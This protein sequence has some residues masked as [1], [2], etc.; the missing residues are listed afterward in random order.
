MRLLPPLLLVVMAAVSFPSLGLAQTKNP[1]AERLKGLTARANELIEAGR[2]ADALAPLRDAWA[3]RQTR[4]LACNIG[5]AER[6]PG[7]DPV[8]A[9]TFLVRCVDWP[10]PP[11]TTQEE[12]ARRARLAEELK[13][14]TKLVARLVIRVEPPGAD[15]LVDG[16]WIA[17]T[18]PVDIFLPKGAHQI[19]A[20]LGQHVQTRSIDAPA[21]VTSVVE[22]SLHRPGPTEPKKQPSLPTQPKIPS[23]DPKRSSPDG[24]TIAGTAL[25]SGSFVASG[26]AFALSVSLRIQSD[27]SFG[28]A[29]MESAN[30]CARLSTPCGEFA[31]RRDAAGT[32]QDIGVAAAVGAVTFGVATLIYAK[33]L[34]RETPRAAAKAHENG[35]ILSW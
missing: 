2:Y 11:A 8:E 12:R 1:Q 23:A 33:T 20:K 29:R 13:E 9:A 31:S 35:V 6:H 17:S 4:E 15:V 27:T 24:I 28:T 18:S 30:A 5:L 19:T 21:G 3:I 22:L 10:A 25:G 14:A 7:G 32:F 34:A 16:R 26:V